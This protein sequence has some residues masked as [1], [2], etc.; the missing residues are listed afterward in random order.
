MAGQ[1]PRYESGKE[2]CS[3]GINYLQ[4]VMFCACKSSGRGSQAVSPHKHAECQLSVPPFI[5]IS[6][7]RIPGTRHSVRNASGIGFIM[8]LH[9]R[10]MT[11]WT[12][13]SR[14]LLSPV[15][16]DMSEVLPQMLGILVTCSRST[17]A[18]H[19]FHVASLCDALHVV[20]LVLA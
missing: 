1:W 4:K 9:V 3:C 14:A 19:R 18:Q 7:K 20:C 2:A 6:R 16:L 11:S 13:R 5:W 15:R 8:L 12:I 10:M 17:S